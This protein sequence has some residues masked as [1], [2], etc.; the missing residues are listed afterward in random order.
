MAVHIH[1]DDT[2]ILKK[3]EYDL[4]TGYFI[5]FLLPIRDGLPSRD[6]FSLESFEEI[7][8]AYNSTA[9]SSYAH[10]IV[11]QPISI[12]APSFFLFVLGSDSKYTHKE[13]EH[14]WDFIKQEVD[15]R[16][17]VT[18]SNGSDGAGPFLKAMVNKCKIFHTSDTS[19]VPPHWSFYVMPK[20]AIDSLNAQDTVNLMAKLRTKL[21]TP[22]NLIS[23]GSAMACRG[24]LTD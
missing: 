21:V 4:I 11:A 13:I 3:V 24:H 22:S 10:C 8:M 9:V 2:R 5:G 18:L 16:N 14:R 1:L 23:I 19:N 17:V 15:K 20:L 12:E 6:G 7:E